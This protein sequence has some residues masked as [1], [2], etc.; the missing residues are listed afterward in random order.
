MGDLKKKT[1]VAETEKLT[2]TE[3]DTIEKLRD[4]LQIFYDKQIEKLDKEES[5]SKKIR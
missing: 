4:Y 2:A 1:K 5:E 3:E